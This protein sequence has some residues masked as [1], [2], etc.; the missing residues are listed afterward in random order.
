MLIIEHKQI[1]RYGIIESGGKC[2]FKRK[3]GEEMKDGSNAYREAKKGG[4]I[5]T[6]LKIADRFAHT[7]GRKRVSAF[8]LKRMKKSLVSGNT[9]RYDLLLLERSR[10]SRERIGEF[11]DSTQ[12]PFQDY[13]TFS[14]AVA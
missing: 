9:R 2:F 5:G 11:E 1:A 13:E 14:Q 7:N 12:D 3:G 4:D 8:L 10:E 6:M